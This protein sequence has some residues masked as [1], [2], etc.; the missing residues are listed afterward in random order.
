MQVAKKVFTLLLPLVARGQ[1]GGALGDAVATTQAAAAAGAAGADDAAT[2][3]TNNAATNA[4]AAADDAS[5]AGASRAAANTAGGAAA[6]VATVE[7]ADHGLSWGHAAIGVLRRTLDAIVFGC[8]GGEKGIIRNRGRISWG[9][10]TH[11]ES[12]AGRGW[13]PLRSCT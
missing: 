9:S 10:A 5:L 3:T 12:V 1:V 8:K 6:G 11:P 4:A 7:N 2:N 13:P